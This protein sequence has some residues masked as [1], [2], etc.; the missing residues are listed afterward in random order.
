MS[1]LSTTG[2]GSLPHPHSDAALHYV[3]QFDLPYAPQLPKRSPK[4]GMIYQTLDG[5]G[6]LEIVN[7]GQVQINKINPANQWPTDLW[8]DDSYRALRPFLFEAQQRKTAKIKIQLTGA[9]TLYCYTQYQQNDLDYFQQ[10][11]NFLKYK[12]DLILQHG[13]FATLYLQ[14]DEPALFQLQASE[15]EMFNNYLK[16]IL[17]LRSPQVKIGF[18]C[19]SNGQW[20]QL[21]N[22]PIDFL[23]FDWHLSINNLLENKQELLNISELFLGVLPTQLD[24]LSQF[25]PLTFY[26]SLEKNFTAQERRALLQKSYIT[27]SCGLGHSDINQLSQ[28]L[29]QQQQFANNVS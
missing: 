7:S 10:L 4:E 2:I 21:L 17:Q 27:P 18:H 24:N 14:I 12:M 26:S 23:S 16:K 15:F 20:Q 25:S 19:C 1:K 3:F 22:H 5:I 13:H 28:L 8:F 6:E 11:T 29:I 9:Y